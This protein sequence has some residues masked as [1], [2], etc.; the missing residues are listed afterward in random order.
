MK[1][2]YLIL[3]SYGHG[4]AEKRFFELWLNLK[5]S[6][7]LYLIISKK[8]L[9]DF[10][11]H[12]NLDKKIFRDKNIIIFNCKHDGYFNKFFGILKIIKLINK[13]SI[14]HFPLMYM[15]FIS[16][17]RSSKFII[18]WVAPY[19]YNDKKIFNIKLIIIIFLSFLF[20]YKIDIINPCNYIYLN[21]FRIFKNKITL[22]KGGSF[23][24]QNIY[25]P[26]KKINQ[27][28][29][30][31]RFVYEKGILDFI[32]SLH[33]LFDDFDKYNL[34]IP[35]IIIL[36]HGKLEYIINKKINDFKFK[37][38]IK[39]L[40]T[41]RP[42]EYMSVSSIFLSLQKFSNY[43]SK[44]LIESMYCGCI[45]I[46]VNNIDSDNMVPSNYPFLINRIFD[47]KELSIN[48]IKI[49]SLNDKE[50]NEL[51]AK[52]RNYAIKNFNINNQLLYFKKMYEFEDYLN[53]S[54]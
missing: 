39:V 24:D 3:N 30:V 7:P 40:K 45:P 48:I 12:Y 54:T 41:N 50:I 17:F 4:G 31:G 36:G 5:N 2:I 21:K 26:Q 20:A 49:L 15:P 8:T 29:F 27:I 34:N 19:K 9:E 25:H 47:P 23:S 38:K 37:N 28:I 32:N 22:T 33:I 10:V 14:I 16:L 52:V 18:S 53:K 44:S 6:I 42:W 51:R 13:N 1:K 46:I 11:E 35:N 43:P